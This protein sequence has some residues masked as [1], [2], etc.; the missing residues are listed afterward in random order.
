MKIAIVGLGPGGEDAP[1]FDWSWQTWALLIDT[2]ARSRADV[3]FEMHQMHKIEQYGGI[4]IAGSLGPDAR[5]FWQ[6]PTHGRFVQYP[7]EDVIADLGRDWFGSTIAYMVALAIHRRPETIGLW[8]I[9][10][11]DG[12]EFLYQRANLS[13]LLGFAEGRGI[14]VEL[15]DDCRLLRYDGKDPVRYGHG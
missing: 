6:H 8:G 3:L 9:H 7:L 1:F 11:D 10:M 14:K 2:F 15:P 5:V 4:E 13:W 12:K